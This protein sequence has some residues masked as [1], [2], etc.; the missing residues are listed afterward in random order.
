MEITLPNT[1]P[2]FDVN[3]WGDREVK[4]NGCKR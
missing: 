1:N 3:N 4:V 2:F